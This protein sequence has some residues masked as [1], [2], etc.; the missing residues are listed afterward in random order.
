MVSTRDSLAYNR[1]KAQCW[2]S[3]VDD[4]IIPIWNTLGVIPGHIKD[5]VIVLGNH[6]DGESSSCVRATS[7]SS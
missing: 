6:R 3:L 5:E 2:F 7:D 4:K 1:L